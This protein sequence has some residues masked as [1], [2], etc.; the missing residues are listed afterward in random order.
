[1]TS[2]AARPQWLPSWIDIS[3]RMSLI[4][5]PAAP[6][7]CGA[8][9]PVTACS[10][11][12]RMQ[13]PIADAARRFPA[14]L[15]QRFETLPA[16]GHMHGQRRR[17][18]TVRCAA[19]RAVPGTQKVCTQLANR[20]IFP[21]D[22]LRVRRSSAGLLLAATVVSGLC[23]CWL[24]RSKHRMDRGSPL[25]HRRLQREAARLR[26]RHSSNGSSRLPSPG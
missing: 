20:N 25:H 7:L 9:S 13:S 10:M 8:S 3:T 1:M 2:A 26:S 19:G 4:R 6:R 22:G 24:G 12:L 14:S 17:H 16:A 5:S 15:W 11:C 21:T 23:R 18:K